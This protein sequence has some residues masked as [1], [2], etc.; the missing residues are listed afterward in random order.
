MS[1]TTPTTPDDD[2]Y[3][4]PASEA[5]QSDDGPPTDAFTDE[6]RADS[7]ADAEPDDGDSSE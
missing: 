7:A 5:P 2:E 6:V 3:S 4:E 1:D